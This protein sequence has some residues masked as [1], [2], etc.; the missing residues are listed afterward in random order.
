[1]LWRLYFA[2]CGDSEIKNNYRIFIIFQYLV[3]NISRNLVFFYL[4]F[5]KKIRMIIRKN[6]GVKEGLHL[7]GGGPFFAY[8]IAVAGLL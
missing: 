1:M 3:Y 6:S 2:L 5:L 7:N 4:L 8:I